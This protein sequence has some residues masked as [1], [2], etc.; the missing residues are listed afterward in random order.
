MPE[1]KFLVIHLVV[2]IIMLTFYGSI[3]AAREMDSG[4][5]TAQQ[6]R[7]NEITTPYSS[8][9]ETKHIYWDASHG[10]RYRCNTDDDFYSIAQELKSRGYSMHSGEWSV[11]DLRLS[12]YSA[13]VIASCSAEDTSYSNEEVNAIYD[14]VA[15]GGG[16]LIM[17]KAPF[18]YEGSA[19]DTH[20]D[21]N[22]NI[23][24][25]A[26]AFGVNFIDYPWDDSHLLYDE[27]TTTDL[28][29]HLLF[30][31]VGEL[32]MKWAGEFNVSAPAKELAWQEGL[33][34]V[35]AV[36]DDGL[37]G[38]VVI[39][40]DYWFMKDMTKAGNR[41][42]STNIFDWFSGKLDP[43][44][45][46]PEIKIDPPF[47][48]FGEVEVF[49]TSPDLPFYIS[50]EGTGNLEIYNINLTGPDVDEFNITDDKCS[51]VTLLPSDSCYLLSEFSPVFVGKKEAVI[52]VES[53]DPVLYIANATLLGEGTSSDSEFVVNI[54]SDESD[55][56]LSDNK[57]KAEISEES[58]K[59][60]LRAAIEQANAME[61]ENTI[62]VE[63]ST[64][65]PETELPAVT[66]SVTIT[67]DFTLDGKNVV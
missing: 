34:V 7:E 10:T 8:S 45:E 47:N 36:E 64:I 39:T 61:G 35:A 40:G 56:D 30:D 63:V 18:A 66:D 5:E 27:F 37:E 59:C 60:T 48:D 19:S 41:Q 9:E 11:L 4:A 17:G 52:D 57:C 26:E 67:G 58:N 62:K 14:F 50:N 33:V 6:F 54:E 46:K 16:L 3:A 1:K 21:Y 25:V 13:I 20:T 29:T 23:K 49:D 12:D 2:T 15:S 28:S 51:W 65:L 55:S 44:T 22:R 53:N 31:S 42:F 32:T 38:K 43:E 24:P